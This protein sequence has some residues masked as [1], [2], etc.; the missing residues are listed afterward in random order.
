MKTIDS[1][2]KV[3][4]VIGCFAILA[5]FLGLFNSSSLM[6]QFFPLYTGFTLLGTALLHKDNTKKALK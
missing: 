3:V 5:G 1:T 2:K 6:E 4:L